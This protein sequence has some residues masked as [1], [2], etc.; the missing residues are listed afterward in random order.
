MKIDK[1]V[2][3]V[4][5]TQVTFDILISIKSRDYYLQIERFSISIDN[6]THNGDLLDRFKYTDDDDKFTVCHKTGEKMIKILNDKFLALLN[7]KSE[8][9]GL[10]DIAKFKLGVLIDDVIEL[11]DKKRKSSAQVIL[12]AGLLDN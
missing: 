12:A 1:I 5:D 6:F 11:S 8:I 4:L 2:Y 7:L 9:I 10:A 3:E